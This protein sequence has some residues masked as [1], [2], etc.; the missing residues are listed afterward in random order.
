MK[1]TDSTLTVSACDNCDAQCYPGQ[2][3]R[4]PGS[5]GVKV[6]SSCWER[7]KKDAAE[8][9][10]LPRGNQKGFELS[11]DQQA[12]VDEILSCYQ[13]RL[14]KRKRIIHLYND[15]RT[16]T[17]CGKA[18]DSVIRCGEEPVLC[19]DCNLISMRGIRNA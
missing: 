9:S 3:F 19:E 8:M 18:P 6:C 13:R 7:D 16:S 15:D 1:N 5:V 14:E 12:A 2:E 10:L 4:P 11:P 17:I